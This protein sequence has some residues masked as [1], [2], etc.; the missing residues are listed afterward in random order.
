MNSVFI[1]WHTRETNSTT[2]DKLIGVYATSAD[3]EAAICR[4]KEK[5]G[6]RDSLDGFGVFEYVVGRD[7]WTEGFIS[8]AEATDVVAK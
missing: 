8:E 7:G 3:A 5:P 6:F 4:L 2:G 1:L